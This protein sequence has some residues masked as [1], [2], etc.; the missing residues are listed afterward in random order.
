MK[1]FSLITFTLIAIAFTLV[2][3]EKCRTCTYTYIENTEEKI[4]RSQVC[5]AKKD[6]DSFEDF[7]AQRAD[8]LLVIYTCIEE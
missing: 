1:Y 4:Y 6:L 8:S 5:G 7:V 3:C 2:G